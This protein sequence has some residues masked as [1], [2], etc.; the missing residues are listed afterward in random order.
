MILYDFSAF[1]ETQLSRTTRGS[2]TFNFDYF[3]ESRIENQSKTFSETSDLDDTLPGPSP[4]LNL[5]FP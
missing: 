4:G 5:D 3:F 2:E 1:L